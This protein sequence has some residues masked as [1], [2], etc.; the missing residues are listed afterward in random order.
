MNNEVTEMKNAKPEYQCPKCGSTK[1]LA[2]ASAYVD[3]D[4]NDGTLNL[5]SGEVDLD[6][7]SKIKNSVACNYC[8][9]EGTPEQF[10]TDARKAA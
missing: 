3:L 10:E 9:H 8:E 1:L 6:F 5:V 7:D 4:G 2:H